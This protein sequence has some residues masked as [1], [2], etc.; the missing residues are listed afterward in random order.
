MKS[1]KK[2]FMGIDA[3]GTYT[4]AILFDKS[5]NTIIQS[6]KSLTTYP[7]PLGGIQSALSKFNE[8]DLKKIQL[9]SV[10]T[11]FA[12]NAI[13][14]DSRYPVGLI[15]IGKQKEADSFAETFI[16]IKGGHNYNGIEAEPL[17]VE[18][19]KSFVNET[20]GLV[21]SYAISSVYSVL[22]PEHEL[23]AKSIIKELTDFPVVCGHEL[24]MSLG[25]FERAQTAYLN[26]SLIPVAKKFTDSVVKTAED[27]GI[28]AKITM[29]KCN[30]AAALLSEVMEKPIETIFSG[31]AASILGGSFLSGFDTCIAI[32][33]GG[34]S[35]DISMI[36]DGIPEIS[37]TGAKV[38]GW[39]TKVRALKIETIALGGDSHVWIES[40]GVEDLINLPDGIDYSDIDTGDRNPRKGQRF[41]APKELN[42]GPK[43]VMP[44]CRAATMFPDFI[45]ILK[46]RWVPFNQKLTDFIQPTLFYINSCDSSLA[47]TDEEKKYI[48][49]VKDT[50]TLIGNKN[51]EKNFVPENILKSLVSKRAV[52]MVGFT[53]TDALHVLGDFSEWNS[54]ASEI[55]ATI[56]GNLLN[57]EKYSFCE[58][59]KKTFT[60]KMATEAI[61]FLNDSFKRETIENFLGKRNYLKMKF[62]IPIILIGAP[63]SSYVEELNFLIDSEICVP[64]YYDVG[65]AIGALS[66][67]FAKRVEVGI[68]IGVY[69]THTGFKE[70][71][72]FVYTKLGPTKFHTKDEAINFVKK[73]GREQ[74]DEYMK[75]CNVKPEDISYRESFVEY[76]SRPE[77][78]PFNI[79][80]TFE[81]FAENKV[82]N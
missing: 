27:L 8:S 65:N 16:H 51:W 34:T 24:T 66:G 40:E 22:N 58:H 52:Q 20:K 72:I 9:L 4:D 19:I 33:V 41:S 69:E 12:T 42:I 48:S 17:D 74:I 29:L 23:L 38:G 21:S 77:R 56:L 47:L 61:Y 79:V 49:V 30:G 60:K 59:I 11:T 7:D 25:A 68:D 53:P 63:V 35:T 26:A 71:D 75:E 15:M 80:Y 6:A 32:D 43:R 37:D 36:E 76:R 54:E 46:N 81:G 64:E 2:L 67:K 45:E 5:T 44:L 28:N 57:M 14:E 39:S 3:G 31:P 62:D 10:S 50:P 82:Q 55:G 1:P 70:K 13:L 73:Y 78:P 18:A